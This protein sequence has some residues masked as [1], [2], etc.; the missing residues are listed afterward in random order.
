MCACA[1]VCVYVCV[2]ARVCVRVCVCVCMCVIESEREP[3]IS[4]VAQT[5]EIKIKMLKGQMSHSST[6]V[7]SSPKEILP[8][9]IGRS[10][11]IS[12]DI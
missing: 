6:L 3:L 9:L 12:A 8:K 7:L 1:C 4:G 10:I 11:L 5:K 2:C